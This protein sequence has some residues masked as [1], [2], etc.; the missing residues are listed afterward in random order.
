MTTCV[1][2]PTY[3]GSRFVIEQMESLLAQSVHPD[4][5]Y[6]VD[7]CSSDNTVELVEN[8][9]TQYRLNWNFSRNEKNKGWKQNFYDLLC[10]ANEDLI[11]LCDQDDVWHPKKIELMKN[12]MEKNEKIGLLVCKRRDTKNDFS[13]PEL[14]QETRIR[15]LPFDTDF[16]HMTHSGCC[17]CVRKSF[18]LDIKKYWKP[19]FPHDAFLLQ[20]ARLFDCLYEINQLLH[21]CRIHENNASKCPPRFKRVIDFT[22]LYAAYKQLESACPVD[23]NVKKNILEGY[24]YFIRQ[25]QKFFKTK[26]PIDAIKLFLYARFF[27]KGGGYY[28]R[29]AK[30]FAVDVVIAYKKGSAIFESQL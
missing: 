9:I 5:V 12:E 3:N 7:D 15:K 22:Y 16:F 20:N 23:D 17:H 6:I 14:N 10:F 18:F 1:V 25:R 2:L 21:I 28:P 13:F 8:F 27:S 24:F 11:F 19:C 29:G 4:S 26:N 30:T